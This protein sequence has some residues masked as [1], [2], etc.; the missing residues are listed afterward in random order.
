MKKKLAVLLS[1]LVLS[2][3]SVTIPSFNV[4][5]SSNISE[6]SQNTTSSELES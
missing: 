6:S 1:L 3:C 2:S 5:L 4:S